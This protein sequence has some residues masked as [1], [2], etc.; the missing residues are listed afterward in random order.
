M[1]LIAPSNLS[2]DLTI[3]PLHHVTVCISSSGESHE[4]NDS[5]LVESLA[6]NW[7]EELLDWILTALVFA[8]GYLTYKLLPFLMQ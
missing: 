7:K 3:Q 8:I 4:D 1:L 5:C 6:M 2:S